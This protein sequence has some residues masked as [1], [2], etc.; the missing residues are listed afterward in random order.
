MNWEPD[1]RTVEEL[2]SD[3]DARVAR[4]RAK[5]IQGLLLLQDNV[6]GMY[7]RGEITEAQFKDL[8]TKLKELA[9]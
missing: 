3:F 6:K 4:C 2:Q 8:A 7:N 1:P 9:R 5:T